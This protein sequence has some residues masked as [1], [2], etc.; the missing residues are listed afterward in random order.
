MQVTISRHL[1][2]AKRNQ[3]I[4]EY[5]SVNHYRMGKLKKSYRQ[6]L[7]SHTL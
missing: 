2:D 3:N 1:N 7:A 6:S 5:C 4:V